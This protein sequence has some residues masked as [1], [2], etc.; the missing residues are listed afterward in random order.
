MSCQNSSAPIN[1]P[2]PNSVYPCDLKCAYNFA[3]GNSSCNIKN[4]QNYVSLSYDRRSD[5]KAI[6]YNTIKLFVQEVRL[7]S[8]SIHKYQGKNADAELLIIHGG[9]GTNL[10]V[11]V[12]IVVGSKISKGGALLDGIIEQGLP[13]ISNLGESATL[14]I[15]NYNLDYLVPS[16]PYFS[17]SGTLPY[18]P[19]SGKYN[20]IVFDIVNAININ[21]DSLKQLR[22]VISPLSVQLSD[23]EPFYNKLGP[24]QGGSKENE[25]YIECNPTGDDGE[26]LLYN[27]DANDM[28]DYEKQ[29]QDFLQSPI[30][31]ILVSVA[32]I[33]LGVGIIN[34]IAQR[35]GKN[36]FSNAVQ[37]LQ[38][39]LKTT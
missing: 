20:Y 8:P 6:T 26:V 38:N 25:I 36:N 29:F 22:K 34:L 39:N 13:R 7:Y 31:K 21:N 14:N 28:G 2:S 24:N 1:I 10:I 3:Y 35:I 5:A 12:P 18:P 37:T 16:R 30:F 32:I 15:D 17:Y 4:E 9:N 23:S 27:N 11:S 33:L 19:C